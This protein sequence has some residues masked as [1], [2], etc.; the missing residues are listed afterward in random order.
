MVR[1]HKKNISKWRTVLN[2]TIT[3]NVCFTFL[4]TL[5]ITCWITNKSCEN[6][7]LENSQNVIENAG[8]KHKLRLKCTAVFLP[9]NNEQNQ[10]KRN[11]QVSKIFKS[12]PT[13]KKIKEIMS[14]TREDALKLNDEKIKIEKVSFILDFDIL[15]A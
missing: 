11:F 6:L 4:N 15:L 5:L 7:K 8:R 10:N 3:I 14:Y 2:L 9:G 1:Y 12:F 13:F